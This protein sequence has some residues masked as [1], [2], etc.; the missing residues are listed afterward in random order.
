M[1]LQHNIIF[2]P[3]SVH[4]QHCNPWF[5]WLACPV[6]VAGPCPAV[7]RR[8]ERLYRSRMID[9]SIFT[10]ILQQTLANFSSAVP[11]SQETDSLPEKG[12]RQKP[13]DREP[14]KMAHI[15]VNM[16]RIRRQNQTREMLRTGGVSQ[17][18]K[19]DEQARL[20]QQSQPS[21]AQG[22]LLQSPGLTG[23]TQC[24]T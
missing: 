14:A 11:P 6:S 20:S 13:D 16:H 9:P 1:G 10:R 12:N 18:Y 4:L 22:T 21:T 24:T 2:L 8:E 3:C 23:T 5:D 19:Y 7:A 15:E 17:D